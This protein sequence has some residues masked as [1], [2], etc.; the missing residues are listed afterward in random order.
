MTTP[1]TPPNGPAPAPASA[2]STVRTVSSRAPARAPGPV[3]KM[4]GRTPTG[5]KGTARP[6]GKNHLIYKRQQAAPTAPVTASGR[7]WPHTPGATPKEP[8]PHG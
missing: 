3:V 1:V 5:R 2:A 4:R 7:R 8:T 6:S